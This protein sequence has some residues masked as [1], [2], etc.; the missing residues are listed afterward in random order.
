MPL[1]DTFQE[2]SAVHNRSVIIVK[3][4]AVQKKPSHVGIIVSVS[5]TVFID[6]AHSGVPVSAAQI[7]C[8]RIGGV[9]IADRDHG[10]QV[11]I[12]AVLPVLSGQEIIILIYGSHDIKLNET[13][14]LHPVGI[15]ASFRIS[16]D[17]AH[18]S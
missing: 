6:H 4:I 13:C 1:V 11:G 3:F 5:H 14:R 18:I 16:G 15:N 17:I 10:I 8:K 2:V 9:V 12:H 7:G